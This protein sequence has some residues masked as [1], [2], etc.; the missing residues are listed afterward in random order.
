MKYFGYK[1]TGPIRCNNSG[2]IDPVKAIAQRNRG[3]SILGFKKVCFHLGINKFI[4]EPESSSRN[5]S[6]AE[7]NTQ[8]DNTDD[9]D[10]YPYPIPHNLPKFFVEPDDFVPRIRTMDGTSDSSKENIHSH[11]T[12]PKQGESIHALHIE[13]HCKNLDDEGEFV[14]IT[15]GEFYS[16]SPCSIDSWE[17][18]FESL[19]EETI[20]KDI[21]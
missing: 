7:S 2:L 19:F 8:E 9:E 10:P 6:K 15:V 12:Q 5:E 3:T 21:D 17:Y 16:L 18:E 4:P 20:D 14:P 1:G 11:H 13:Y